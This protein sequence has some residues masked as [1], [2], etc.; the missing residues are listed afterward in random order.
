MLGRPGGR[1]SMSWRV[2]RVEGV[3]SSWGGTSAAGVCERALPVSPAATD[4]HKRGGVAVCAPPDLLWSGGRC[5]RPDARPSLFVRRR[6]GL[7][8]VS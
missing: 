3:P 7:I 5:G 6:R 2:G 4:C 1:E 8:T